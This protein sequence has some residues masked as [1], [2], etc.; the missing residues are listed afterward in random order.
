MKSQVSM[1]LAGLIVWSA[2]FAPSKSFSSE[3]VTLKQAIQAG[4]R[5]NP[6]TQ[7]NSL[8]LQ[9]AFEQVVA[10]RQSA[11]LPRA[12]IGMTSKLNGQRETTR[13]L[14]VNLNLFNGF[15]DYYRIKAQECNYKRTEAVYNSTNAF[16][17]N[18]SGQIVGL[19][20]DS[21][22]ELIRKRESLS[23]YRKL[24]ERIEKS[25][26]VAKNEAQT[27]SLLN[28]KDTILIYIDELESEIEIQ[29]T[30]YEAAVNQPVPER[31]TSFAETLASI[32]VPGTAQDSFAISLE[33]S[34]DILSARL[35]L[36]CL[37]Y[38][39][40]A[41]QANLYSARVD[42]NYYK[43]KS[44]AGSSSK[45]D[46][47]QVRLSVP[48]DLGAINSHLAEAK[49]ISAAELDLDG[50][51][52]D[53]QKDLKNTYTTL[54]SSE[55]SILSYERSFRNNEEKIENYMVR[56]DSLNV[57]QIDDLISLLSSSMSNRSNLNYYYMQT[58]NLKYSIQRNIGTLFETNFL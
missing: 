23:F 43:E 57:T 45:N 41:N 16:I 48:F 33:K 4:L 50:A 31:I 10:A 8:R 39:Y 17:Q 28:L 21:Y 25:L 5:N 6:R 44:S 24:N 54:R 19:I 34:P 2:S 14:S 29:E 47:V 18:T 53:V 26:L 52:S 58:I 36:E 49:E 3:V 7:A 12:E 32:D 22:V 38:A 55:R 30:N 51:I 56:L 15:A 27:N 20:V 11:Y 46:S 13:Y 9:A 40:Q 42:L 1:V 35:N 37:K